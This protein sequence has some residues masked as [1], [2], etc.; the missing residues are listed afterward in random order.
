[1]KKQGLQYYIHDG[2]AALRIQLMGVID[3]GETRRIGQVWHTASSSIFGRSPIIDITFVS[4]V[5][6]AGRALLLQ[7]QQAGAH[8][9]ANSKASRALAEAI[10]GAAVLKPETSPR[11][12]AG[13]T[14]ARGGRAFH[15]AV[16]FKSFA[17]VPFLL[18][19]LLF[20]LPASAATLKPETVAAW[21]AYVE[22]AEANLQ[23][24]TR[25]GG[26]FLWTL[27]RPE[28]AVRVHSGEILV[29][30]VVAPV[31]PPERGANP[32]AVPGGLIHHWMGA[33]FLP[34][35]T[36]P[37]VL[38]VTRDYD[39][40]KDFYR[41]SVVE[42]AAVARGDAGDQFSMRIMNKALF[43]KIALDADYQ[44]TYVLLDANRA[45]GISRTTRL[46]EIDEYGGRAEHE[47][48]EGE[49]A[50]YMWKLLS[51]ARLE[52][53]DGGVY[54]ELEAIALSREIP[55]AARFFVDPIVRRV[56]RNALSVSLQQ[57]R[58]ALRADTPLSAHRDG[59]Q[60]VGG[61]VAGVAAK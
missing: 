18:V 21:D 31:A 35:L 20:S 25:P 45:Y 32:K 42:S 1:M 58:A 24:R 27:E 40:Y 6:A 37:R 28:R 10:L 36:L 9:V 11:T 57:T 55:A 7:W 3:E 33:V 54:L 23:G 2:P 56:S 29:V 43:L 50:G 60:A 17:N 15:R 41:P 49:G 44:A 53:R 5:D 52:Q 8:F 48:P 59:A 30:P 19:A 38:E 22:G 47:A 61:R 13:K 16:F 26:C 46:Q 51:I 34:G 12:P 14:N 4:G 39:R